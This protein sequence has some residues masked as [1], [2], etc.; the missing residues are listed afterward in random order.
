VKINSEKDKHL[1]LGSGSYDLDE[2]IKLLPKDKRVSIE[3]EKTSKDNL[4]D[5]I[6]DCK[7]LLNALK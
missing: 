7:S 4:D 6:E 3:T 1:N 2:I 5:F